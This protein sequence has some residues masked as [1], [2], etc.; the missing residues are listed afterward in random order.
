MRKATITTVLILLVIS[1][2]GAYGQNAA[3]EI[4]K[5]RI[6]MSGVKKMANIRH[7]SDK[8]GFVESWKKVSAPYFI[9]EPMSVLDTGDVVHTVP[10]P[11][12]RCQGLTYDGSSLW[13]SDIQTD[14]IYEISP[15]DGTVLSS[16][17]TT[18]NYIEGLAWDGTYLWA[19]DNGGSSN[20]SDMVYKIDP[21]NGSVVYSFQA[22]NDWTHGIT[23]DGEYLWM[24][25]FDDK[26]LDKV[27]PATGQILTQF[28]A[29][30]DR[31]IGLTWD[32][33]YLWCN[34]I[35]TD[36][37]Y[38]VDP[39]NGNVLAQVISPHTNPRD[40]AWD[41][42]YIWVL[43]WES[44]TIYQVDVG[45]QPTYAGDEAKIPCTFQLLQNY[46][47]PFNASTVIR[48][49]IEKK[50]DVTLTIYDILGREVTTILNET[51]QPGFYDVR[52]DGSE[53]SSGAYFYRLQAGEMVET[54]RMML[55]K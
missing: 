47:N 46:P 11:A 41:G 8:N 28:N 37:L 23:W 31:S 26:T 20:P 49:E 43:S 45:Y 33:E 1:Q 35:G 34:D 9:P 24:N 52:F 17:A 48:F 14:L 39:A 51:K 15:V 55:L 38:R 5:N 16:F 6:D 42:Q 54:K 19:M 3:I 50:S 7:D 32:G 18:G 29:P 12:S 21:A 10:A 53:L 44:A 13:V 2:V 25:D 40:M 36:S 27:D 4:G 22:P 30:G